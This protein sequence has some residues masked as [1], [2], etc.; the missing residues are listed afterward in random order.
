MRS[1]QSTWPIW[2]EQKTGAPFRSLA[3]SILFHALALSTVLLQM[4][5]EQE[6]LPATVRS[7]V[8]SLFMAAPVQRR[9]APHK[10]VLLQASHGIPQIEEVQEPLPVVVDLKVDLN[11]IKLSFENDGSGELPE[12]VRDH[13]G[14][15]ALVDRRDPGFTRYV[16][17]PPD[18]NLR[19]AV[20]DMSG[21]LRLSMSPADNWAVLRESAR[22]HSLD[23]KD[24][25]VCAVFDHAYAKCLQQAI[26]DRASLA[27]DGPK[28]QVQSVRLA[29]AAGKQ[30]GV[31]ILGLTMATVSEDR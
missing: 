15:F 26:R 23:L 27:N 5:F 28:R 2:L 8:T 17:E 16:M 19:E 9:S 3:N 4:P 18:W 14:I 11:A 22:R 24:F 13:N 20:L 21:K 29:F 25:D 6:H 30:C 7:R 1:M 31:D 12:V 10:I